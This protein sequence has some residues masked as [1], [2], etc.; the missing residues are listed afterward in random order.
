MMAGFLQYCQDPFA[1]ERS[2]IEMPNGTGKVVHGNKLKRTGTT[3]P[4][5]H[6]KE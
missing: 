6:M 2:P 5:S 3:K 1:G 4:L